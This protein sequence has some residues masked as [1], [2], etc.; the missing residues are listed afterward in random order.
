MTTPG[1][2]PQTFAD[3]PSGTPDWSSLTWMG[4]I[5]LATETT[6]FYMDNLKME[7]K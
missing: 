6:V 3:L 1:A 2:A 5:S 7:I 4:F